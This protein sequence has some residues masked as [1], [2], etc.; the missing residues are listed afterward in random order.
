MPEKIKLPAI[1]ESSMCVNHKE[2]MG[3]LRMKTWIFIETRV[4]FTQWTR[5]RIRSTR[6]FEPFCRLNKTQRETTSVVFSGRAPPPLVICLREETLIPKVRPLKPSL[7]TNCFVLVSFLGNRSKKFC[8]KFFNMWA[9]RRNAGV[10]HNCQNQTTEQ[11]GLPPGKS[12]R[13]TDACEN[14]PGY[15]GWKTF[16]VNTKSLASM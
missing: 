4:I 1:P 5:C 14:A 8:S 7:H 2:E 10:F 13:I 16:G 12:Q 6:Q 9:N 11:A 15:L 3:P